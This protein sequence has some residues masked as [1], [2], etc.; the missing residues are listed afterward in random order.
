MGDSIENYVRGYKQL[1]ELENY[2]VFVKNF[3]GVKVMCMENYVQS[4]LR[5][6]PT[7]MV[8][9]IEMNDVLTKKNPDK[10]AENIVNLAIKLKI[11]CNVSIS[12]ITTRSDQYQRKVADVSQKLKEKCH[13]KKLQLLTL[14]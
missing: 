11:N 6:I 12:S 14:S 4:T 8:L 7:H 1:R 10:I 3:S 13:E 9:H 2:K 5:E